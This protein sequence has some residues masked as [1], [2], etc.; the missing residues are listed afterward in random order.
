MVIDSRGTKKNSTIVI[1]TVSRHLV[2]TT[3]AFVQ[4]QHKKHDQMPG[5][6]EDKTHSIRYVK[7]AILRNFRCDI[8]PY[9][10]YISYIDETHR[11]LTAVTYF[12]VNQC[13]TD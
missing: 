11:D 5:N 13:K 3:K 10:I 8:Q 4:Y 7:S 2:R 6:E 12:H 1:D 9:T